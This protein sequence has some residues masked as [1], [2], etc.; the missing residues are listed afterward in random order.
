[1][2]NFQKNNKINGNSVWEIHYEFYDTVF[3]ITALIGLLFSAG[4]IYRLTGGAGWEKVSAGTGFGLFMA[5]LFS[6]ILA[7]VGLLLDTNI[8]KTVHN[9]ISR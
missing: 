2:I 6:C 5:G 8:I 1:M 9:I 4:M 7:P 3:R